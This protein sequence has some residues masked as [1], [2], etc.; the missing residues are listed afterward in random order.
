MCK[1]HTQD[2]EIRP[3]CPGF[4]LKSL[5]F[6]SFSEKCKNQG[7]FC[8]CFIINKV[9]FLY[10]TCAW[11]K[12]RKRSVFLSAPIFVWK[13]YPQNSYLANLPF[14]G[15]KWKCWQV[16]SLTKILW[17]FFHKT[18]SQGLFR[19]FLPLSRPLPQPPQHAPKKRK[20]PQFAVVNAC[21]RW[22]ITNETVDLVW[23]NEY[24]K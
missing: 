21:G 23:R 3:F 20:N 22:Y 5:S 9:L 13:I 7:S 10:R 17:S 19:C 8:K 6:L 24:E 11:G 2:S 15:K 18:A 1:K 16:S 4:C 12:L 14:G